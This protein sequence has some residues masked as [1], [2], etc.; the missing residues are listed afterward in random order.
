MSRSHPPAALAAA[1]DDHDALKP[2]ARIGEFLVERVLGVGGFGIVYLAV[3]QVLLRQVAI[4]E[5]MPTALSGRGAAGRVVLRSSAHR[6]TCD[7]GLRAFVKEA[8]LLASF[9]HPSLVKV[10]RF[11]EENGTAYMVMPYY[12]GHT[13]SHRRFAEH[14]PVDESRVRAFMDPLLDAIELLHRS[15]VYHRDISPDNILILPNGRPVLL[16][17]GAARR[18]IGDRT[19]TLTAVLKPS[20]APVEQY[21]DVPGM[22]QGP[23]T[24]LYALG[25]VVH[26]LITGQMPPPAV[27]RAVRDAMPV[28]AAA[29]P[30]PWPR[31]SQGVLAAI[32]WTLAVAPDDRPQSVS[33]LRNALDGVVAPPPPTPRVVVTE[34]PS[35]GVSSGW[36]HTV[37]VAQPTTVALSGRGRGWRVPAM[38][39]VVAAV[40]IG[41][42]GALRLGS[43]T[44]TA[45]TADL[46]GPPVTL[47]AATATPAVPAA[48]AVNRTKSDAAR[49]VSDGAAP[50]PAASPEAAAAD[51]QA[52]ATPKRE[53][54]ARSATRTDATAV[55][56]GSSPAEICSGRNVFMKAVCETRECMRA[57]FRDHPQCTRARDDAD[58]RRDGHP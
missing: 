29:S 47:A 50:A 11:W 40:V 26:H 28:L 52:R 42:W 27:V 39:A 57:R 54:T 55:A 16:D 20:F 14:G 38:A 58:R 32:D 13:L 18:V 31:V 6:D 53:A 45:A 9:D 5:Y 8:Q 44:A 3:D 34:V 17:F 7:T 10:H 2:G 22:R 56:R 30:A 1:T 15:D 4:K 41:G 23:W 21:G 33:E 43:T 51:T 19:Q 49:S 25:A 12:E 48:P 46:S 35:V 36:H 37:R 24:D